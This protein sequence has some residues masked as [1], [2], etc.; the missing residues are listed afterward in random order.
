MTVSLLCLFRHKW[1]GRAIIVTPPVYSRPTSS[2]TSCHIY[3]N[4]I[5]VLFFT[6]FVAA[7]VYCF[8]RALLVTKPY[9]MMY[10]Y[11]NIL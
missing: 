10:V 11:C 9:T 7:A 5:L 3:N 4:N 1:A 6:A 8:C 2:T